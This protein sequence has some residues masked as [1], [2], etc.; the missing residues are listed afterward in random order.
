L[1]TFAD[2]GLPSDSDDRT[3]W[4]FC[5]SE[6]WILLSDNRNLDGPDSLEATLADSWN[7]GCL[8]IL[9]LANKRRFERDPEYA[10]RAANDTADV[11]FGLGMEGEYR[12]RPRIYVPR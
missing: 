12:D 3:V 7:A 5:Q 8:P 9:T 11:L 4:Q 1:V 6:G 10:R 2:L